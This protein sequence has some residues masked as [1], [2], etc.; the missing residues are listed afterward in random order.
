MFH[1]VPSIKNLLL[2]SIDT[3]AKIARVFVH[4]NHFQN[5]LNIYEQGKQQA[6]K[7]IVLL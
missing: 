4:E 2:F 6:M 3:L 7:T 1:P 5:S